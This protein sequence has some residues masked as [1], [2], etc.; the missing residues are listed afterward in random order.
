[1]YDKTQKND[2]IDGDSINEVMFCEEFLK[3]IPLKCINGRFYT[4]DG[5]KD[6]KEIEKEVTDLLKK[7]KIVSVH[8]PKT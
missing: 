4:V 5:K 2:W 1:M 7:E 8:C 6:H 3:D